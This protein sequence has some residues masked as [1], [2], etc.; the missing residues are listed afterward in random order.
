M[1]GGSVKCWERWR[2]LEGSKFGVETT[3]LFSLGLSHIS[4]QH[5]PE[6]G[7]PGTEKDLVAVED[8]ALALHLDIGEVFAV[9]DQLQVL[10]QLLLLPVLGLQTPDGFL[11]IFGA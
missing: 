3:N 8:P 10:A 5:G 4:E 1:K 9:E 11:W 6:D 7:G 2:D